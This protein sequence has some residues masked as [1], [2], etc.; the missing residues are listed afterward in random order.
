MVPS[1]PSSAGPHTLRSASPQ[2]GSTPSREQHQNAGQNC[3]LSTFAQ[4]CKLLLECRTFRCANSG[5]AKTVKF[6]LR[7]LDQLEN[8]TSDFGRRSLEFRLEIPSFHLSF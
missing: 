3:R 2:T 4:I 1:P 7:I 6:E 5:R 8:G